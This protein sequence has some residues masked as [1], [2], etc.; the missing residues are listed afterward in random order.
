VRAEEARVTIEDSVFAGIAGTAIAA[1]RSLLEV[2]RTRVTGGRGGIRA[3]GGAA[4]LSGIRLGGL[5]ADGIRLEEAAGDT[6]V[7]DC[8]LRDVLRAGVSIEG[9]AV[10]LRSLLIVGSATALAV[11]GAADVR[12]ERLTLASSGTGL[13]VGAG[14]ALH[15]DRSILWPLELPVDA[16]AGAEL[17]LRDSILGPAPPGEASPAGA[18]L[19]LEAPRFVAPAAGDFRLAPGSPGLPGPSEPGFDSRSSAVP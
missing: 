9:G 5:H 11:G 2:R 13:E 1:D 14:A 10:R 8:V 17:G 12:A 19:V 15:V 16:R 18:G 7:E 3:R 4:R 6:A